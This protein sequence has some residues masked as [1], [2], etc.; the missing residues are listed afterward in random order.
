MNI[1]Y[2]SVFTL[3]YYNIVFS[4]LYYI[5]FGITSAMLTV[6]LKD[7]SIVWIKQDKQMLFNC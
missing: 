2:Y 6:S 1:P 5:I 4:L 7:T 3:L